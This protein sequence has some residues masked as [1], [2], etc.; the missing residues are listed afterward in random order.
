[1]RAFFGVDWNVLPSVGTIHRTVTIPF[2]PKP[3]TK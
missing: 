3:M 1:M 2:A